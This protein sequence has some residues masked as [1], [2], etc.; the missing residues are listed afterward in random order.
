ME[1]Q[2]HIDLNQGNSA[3]SIG[4]D[5]KCINRGIQDINELLIIHS[6]QHSIWEYKA[7]NDQ[8]SIQLKSQLDIYCNIEETILNG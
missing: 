1:I 7:L 3:P 8:L 6:A 4:L 5:I 2:R